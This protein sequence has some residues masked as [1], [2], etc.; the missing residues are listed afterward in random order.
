MSLFY[1]A[2][3]VRMFVLL[4][5]LLF[6]GLILFGI[7]FIELVEMDIINFI[8]IL[9]ET[10]IFKAI[11]VPNYLKRVIKKNNIKREVE[12]YISGFSSLIIVSILIISSFALSLYL[13]VPGDKV[14]YFTA[15]FSGICTGLFLIVSRKKIITH[16][17]GYVMLENGIVVLAFSVGSK[18]PM[19]VNAGILLDILVSVLLFGIFINKIGNVY[20]GF[21]IDKLNKLKD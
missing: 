3:S 5:L 19:I 18:M 4:D 15:A 10:L 11:I 6:Q 8:A 7:A 9:L 13:K 17:I 21:D 16:I 20:K 12:P 14:A 2:I 1:A